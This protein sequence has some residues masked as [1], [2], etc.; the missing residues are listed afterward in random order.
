M[1]TLFEHDEMRSAHARAH[2]HSLHPMEQQGREVAKAG[3]ALLQQVVSLPLSTAEDEGMQ[4][5]EEA[6]RGATRPRSGSIGSAL[7]A[8]RPAEDA[9]TAVARFFHAA[10]QL[11]AMIE[12][13]GGNVVVGARDSAAAPEDA[14]DG[15]EPLAERV[16]RL[17]EAVA[18]KSAVIQRTEAQLADWAARLDEVLPSAMELAS[19]GTHAAAAEAFA[20]AEA[21]AD[22]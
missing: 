18:Q 11:S 16:A 21:A 12:A 6:T 4:G 14:A 15:D 17:R 5:G 7:P 22:G 9:E 8:P 1:K 2:A 3:A 13:K 19:P 10:E 20:A